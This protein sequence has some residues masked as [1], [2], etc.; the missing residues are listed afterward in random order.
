MRSEAALDLNLLVDIELMVM[1]LTEACLLGGIQ[2]DSELV[3][4]LAFG[5]KF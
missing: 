3:F 4:I 1:L 2:A 5:G